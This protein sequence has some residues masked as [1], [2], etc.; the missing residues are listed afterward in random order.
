MYREP[1]ILSGMKA[2][3]SEGRSP[4]DPLEPIS[5]SPE[6]VLI[7]TSVRSLGVVAGKV[8]SEFFTSE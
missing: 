1:V 2:R 4:G 6:S 3:I 5:C 7:S 8:Q